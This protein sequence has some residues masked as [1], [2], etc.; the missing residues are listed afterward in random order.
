MSK[1]VVLYARLSI[2]SEESVSISRQLEAGRDYCRARGWTIIAEHVD[3]GVSASANAPEFR[4]GWQQVLAHGKGT[5]DVVLVWKVDRLAR[6]VLDFLHA[7]EDLK[8]RGA[9]LAAVEDPIDMTTAQGE[10]FATMLA[11]FGQMEAEATRARVKAARAALIQV[12]RVPGGAAP[13]GYFN[14]PNSDGAGKVLTKDPATIGFVVEA[15]SRVLNGH[16]LHSVAAYLDEVAPRTGR[17]NSAAFWTTTVTK[18]ML[19]NPVLAGM[20]LHNPGNESKQRGTEVLRGSD[21]M[22]IVREDT[23]VLSIEEFRT[24][25]QGLESTGPRKAPSESYLAGLV[26]CGECGRK[27]Y[28]NAKTVNGKK[29]RVFQCQGKNGCGQQVT[30]LEV[31]VEKRFLAEFGDQRF[32]R[33]VFAP[34]DYDLTEINN[35]IADTMN[36]M[37]DDEADVME[38]A[39]RL[40]SLKEVRRQVPEVATITTVS[41]GT[42]GEQWAKDPRTAFLFRFEGVRLVKGGRGRNFDQERLSFIESYVPTAP[43]DPEDFTTFI[44]DWI[45]EPRP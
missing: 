12:G 29:V 36:R 11:V 2:A 25:Q 1:R 35:Q 3:D 43:E 34:S 27:M 20:T 17:K 23:A 13:F 40:K 6:R 5:F 33:H 39:E 28:R 15:A 19:Q 44:A 14:A 32:E 41:E 18:R 30:N 42:S 45:A 4:K 8:T 31:I 9:G 26:W 21:G 24:L 37:Q 16:S 38:L 22:P 7:N 10:A